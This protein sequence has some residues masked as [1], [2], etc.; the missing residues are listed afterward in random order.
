MIKFSILLQYL[1]VFVPSRKANMSLFVAVH[2]MNMIIFI[3]YLLHMFFM[4]FL[5]RPREKY[6]NRL[7]TTGSCYDF[8]TAI[9]AT[10]FFN[11]LSDFIILLLPISSIWRL[12]ISLQKKLGILAVFATGILYDLFCQ[13]ACLNSR[14]VDWTLIDQ[15][16]SLILFF[17]QCLRCVYSSVLL[18][19]QTCSIRGCELQYDHHGLVDI[20][21]NRRRNCH[22]LPSSITSALQ[23]SSSSHF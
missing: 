11:V 4:I 3:F 16:E 1:R 12:Q 5:C 13:C 9:K 21:R 20:C 14:P 6:W 23:S 2:S 19:L 17:A 10:G 18:Y 22:H 15:D 8:N 7:I